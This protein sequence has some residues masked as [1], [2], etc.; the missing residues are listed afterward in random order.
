MWH[1]LQPESVFKP[2][3]RTAPNT[4]QYGFTLPVRNS[5][6]EYKKQLLPAIHSTPIKAS[7]DIEEL[8]TQTVTSLMEIEKAAVAHGQHVK[9]I[10]KFGLDGSGHHRIRHQNQEVQSDPVMT[11]YIGAFWCPLKID[12]EELP[13]WTNHLPN[14]TLYA[15]PV[16]LMREKETCETVQDHFKPFMDKLA[17]LE[18][19]LIPLTTNQCC[20]NGPREVVS[21][22]NVVTEISMIDGKM[23][24]IIQGD[25]GAFCHYCT[26]TRAEANKLERIEQGFAIEKSFEKCLRTW[27]ALESGE[28]LYD[29]KGRAGQ[30]YKPMNTRNMQFYGITHQKLRS[31][32]HMEKLLYHLVSGQT[33]TWSEQNWR[34]KDA[35]KLGKSETVELIRQKCGFLI[36]TPTSNGGNT[37]YGGI[38]DRFFGQEHREDIC[39]IILNESDRSAFSKLL[40][41]FNMVLSV[42]QHVDVNK[43]AIPEKVKELSLD[44]MIFHKNN[45]T[46]AMLPPTVHSMCGHNWEMSNITGGAP[47][48]VFSEQGSEAWNKHIRA[49]KS[50]PGARARQTSIK[51]NTLDIFHRMMSKTH[52]IIASQKRQLACIRCNKLGHT[53]RSCPTRFSIARDF[54]TATVQSCF[55]QE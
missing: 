18:N 41:L 17:G 19:D 9:L 7:C 49:F 6:D 35:L 39:S 23:A 28:L 27:Q 11:N 43:I 26:I 29:D 15:R 1:D 53:I 21:N 54:E 24:D 42:C 46:W 20:V 38:A 16:C 47:I 2:V 52:P 50:G 33:H 14:S 44:L 8:I 3:S 36:D 22:L 10:A 34:V 45:F 48:A 37:N 12:I 31:L 40:Q 30:V 32:D 25:A 51:D 5:V 55:K 4:L 13:V